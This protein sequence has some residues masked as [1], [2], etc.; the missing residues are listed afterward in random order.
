[1][2]QLSKD[3]AFGGRRRLFDLVVLGEQQ[4]ELH[5]VLGLLADGSG[6]HFPAFDEVHVECR[7][8]VRV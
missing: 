2:E 5:E 8:E 3:V 7:Y 6:A 1:M 4:E